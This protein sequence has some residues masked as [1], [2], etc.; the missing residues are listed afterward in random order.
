MTN[1]EPDEDKSISIDFGII[2]L[3]AIHDP[4]GDQIL[5]K[6]S[7]IQ[8][9]NEHF[10][11]KIN[12]HRK[13]LRKY[14]SKNIKKEK[15]N[16]KNPLEAQER[17]ID[18]ATKGH[19]SKLFSAIDCI[20]NN[21][22]EPP[23]SDIRELTDMM[24]DNINKIDSN[25][26]KQ[27][28]KFSPLITSYH[29]RKLRLDRG[30]AIDNYFNHLVDWIITKY[31]DCKRIIV[32]YNFGWKTKCNMGKK[33]NKAFYE[34]PCAKFLHKLKCRAEENNQIVCVTEES[35]TSKCDALALEEICRHEK[36][37]GARCKR[38]L[39]SSSTG[40]YINADINGAI[41][42]M[43]KWYAKQGIHMTKITG[44]NLFNPINISISE[45]MNREKNTFPNS[46]DI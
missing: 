28:K 43:R 12:E 11:T 6:G 5:I 21:I 41:N 32:G 39:F 29:L 2:N 16:K 33:N 38:G 8:N 26:D 14:N 19:I 31:S 7:Q 34:I 46:N 17:L 20:D 27:I 18:N 1:N 30:N 13:E 25:K 10:E 24:F 45:I 40:K 3:A 23:K 9:I 42:I 22:S 37:L 4:D 36:Y 44:K 35:Y 15:Q